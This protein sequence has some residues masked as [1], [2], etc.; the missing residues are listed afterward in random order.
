MRF[1][2]P[3]YALGF[4]LLLCA[5]ASAQLQ[6][7]YAVLTDDHADI[8]VNYLQGEWVLEVDDD[9]N[10]RL[11][12]VEQALI[13]VGPGG[14]P[15]NFN[16]GAG[17]RNLRPAGSEWDFIGVSA[18]EP[19]WSLRQ[20]QD[21]NTL[22]LGVASKRT[23]F[24]AL[25][26]YDPAQESGGRV[27]GAAPWIRVELVRVEGPGHL[28]AWHGTGGTPAVFLS[29]AQGGITSADALYVL[30]SGHIHYNWGF[31][32]AGLY[33]I[34]F[35]AVG[36]VGGVQ[37]RSDEFTY[38]FGVEVSGDMSGNKVVGL[39]DLAEMLRVAGGLA[40]AEPQQ[41]LH[42]DMNL[43]GVIDITDAAHLAGLWRP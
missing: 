13:Y 30:A 15:G 19:F 40:A 24:S 7:G 21:P 42:G 4:L 2:N 31:T 3:V 38:T 5:G 37:V 26:S 1:L 43:D 6:P 32:A 25:D 41:M 27:Q 39:E 23:S 36:R 28:S 35:Q 16:P 34:T 18:G 10:L 8:E 17:G 20:F 29:T 11:L 33:R 9:D 22:Y 14:D 12:P